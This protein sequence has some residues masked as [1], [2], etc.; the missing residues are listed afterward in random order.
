VPGSLRQFQGPCG[1]GS[2]TQ[3]DYNRPGPGPNN[4]QYGDVVAT[5]NQGQSID[6]DIYWNAPHGGWHQFRICPDE[7]LN[8][9]FTNSSYTPDQADYDQMEAC[10]S[11]NPITDWLWLGE[12]GTPSSVNVQ[13]PQD[14]TCEHCLLGWRWDAWKSGNEIYNQCSDIAIQ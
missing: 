14:L 9:L 3:H 4:V 8:R 5:Y 7:S 2:T 12:N 11:A 1:K 6:V 13:L 10:H